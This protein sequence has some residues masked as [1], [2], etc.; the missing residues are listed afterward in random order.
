MLI[1][2]ISFAPRASKVALTAAVDF[3][4]TNQILFDLTANFALI[5]E[6]GG[7]TSRISQQCHAAIG[8]NTDKKISLVATEISQRNKFGV[9]PESSECF[10]RWFLNESWFGR[11]IVNREDFEFCRDYGII[12]SADIP[13]PF[14]QAIMII[15]RH[16]HEC[17]LQA[18]EK[19]EELTKK[20]INGNIAYLFCFCSTFSASERNNTLFICKTGHR[21]FPVFQIDSLRNFLIGELGDVSD[22]K[23]YLEAEYHYRVNQSI[24]GVSQMFHTKKDWSRVNPNVISSGRTEFPTAVTDLILNDDAFKKAFRDYRKEQTSGDLYKPPNPFVSS[25]KNRP[26]QP[27]EVSYDELFDFIVPYINKH[28]L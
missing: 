10:L 26:S 6:K 28:F 23:K 1:Q 4:K 25:I 18:F 15:S 24:Y 9:K 16:F 11:F 17:S 8:D 20:G 13:Q 21:A 12:V 27:Y 5:E 7:V 2:E 19:F 22:D 3:L 14:L